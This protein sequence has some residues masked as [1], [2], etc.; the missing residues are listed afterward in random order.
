MC[1][2]VIHEKYLRSIVEGSFPILALQSEISSLTLESLQVRVFL[3][4][5]IK[6]KKYQLLRKGDKTITAD[7]ACDNRN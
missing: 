5:F 3:S 2:S 6:Y 1:H 7:A 4:F